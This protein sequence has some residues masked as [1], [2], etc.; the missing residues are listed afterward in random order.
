MKLRRALL[1]VAGGAAAAL[2]AASP[3]LAAGTWQVDSSPN[4]A[5]S[6]FSQLNASFAASHTQAWAVGQ[7]RVAASGD[8]FETLIEEWNG[9]TWSVVPGAPASVSASSLNGVSGSG[10]SDIWAVGQNSSAGFIEHWNGQSWSHVA[11][12]ASEPPDGQLNAVSA[13]SPTDAWAGGSAVNAQSVVTPLIEHWNGTQWSVSPDAIFVNNGRILSIAAI[14]PADVWALASAGKN[15]AVIEHWNGSTWSIVSLP[16]SGTLHSLSAVSAN[17][18][19][20]VGSD[21]LILNWNG[22]QWSQVANP[23]G[24]G[25][26]LEAVDALSANDVWAINSLGTVTEQWNGTQWTAVPTASPLPAG[27]RV[28]DGSG[29]GGGLSGL[30]GGP[31][32][33]VGD[34]GDN[35][36]AILQ[37]AP[38]VTR[39]VRPGRPAGA[40]AALDQGPRRPLSSAE[41]DGPL[42]RVCGTGSADRSTLTSR[43]ARQRAGM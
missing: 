30:T 39:G 9:S 31:L 29:S 43:T 25:A 17:D 23:A 4:P 2:I 8:G 26:A 19:W 32:F 33:A 35:Q 5:G 16:V 38:A 11:S 27:F 3:A 34:N 6:T 18:V 14:S 13:D 42:V 28:A 36:T 37:Q 21:G 22:T 24:Q 41:H 15:P 1:A 40:D 10:P 20:A 7:T 12:P